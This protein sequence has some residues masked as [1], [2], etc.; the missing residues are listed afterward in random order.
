MSPATHWTV[1]VGDDDGQRQVEDICEVSLLPTEI[2][3]RTGQMTF[4]NQQ[5]CTSLTIG[6]TCR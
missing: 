6:L 2:D 4:T 1:F 3:F 5:S